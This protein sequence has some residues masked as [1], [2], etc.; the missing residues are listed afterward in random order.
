MRNH[1][2]NQ[3]RQRQEKRRRLRKKLAATTAPEERN[4]ILE[5]I[6]KT[7]PKYMPEVPS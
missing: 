1:E 4:A 5:K 2:I 6:R 3:R 7:Y